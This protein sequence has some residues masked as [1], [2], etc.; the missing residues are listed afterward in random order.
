MRSRE[1]DLVDKLG[2]IALQFSQRPA[3]FEPL[4]EHLPS[5]SPLLSDVASRAL[6]L[7]VVSKIDTG[8][9][10]RTPLPTFELDVDHPAGSRKCS[11]FTNETK[12]LEERIGYV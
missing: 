11:I 9:P 7:P 1:K 10:S 12:R 4:V 2:E 6:A 3:W 8:P 5:V